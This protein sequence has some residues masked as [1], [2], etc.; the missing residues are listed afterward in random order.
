GED[1]L[2]RAHRYMMH[3]VDTLW[4]LAEREGLKEQAEVIRPGFLRV[5]TTTKYLKKIR[6]EVKLMNR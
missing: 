1:Y 6:D 3:A 5:G 2:I 4:E